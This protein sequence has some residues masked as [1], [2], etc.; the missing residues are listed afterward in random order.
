MDLEAPGGGAWAFLLR[1][2]LV[3]RVGAIDGIDWRRG[4]V[5][6]VAAVPFEVR[7]LRTREALSRL[8]LLLLI[9]VRIVGSDHGVRSLTAVAIG[10]MIGGGILVAGVPVGEARALTGE[11]RALLFRK[12]KLGGRQDEAGFANLL[13]QRRAGILDAAARKDAVSARL[14]LERAS[15]EARK[16]LLGSH[17]GQ[18]GV[19][20]NRLAGDAGGKPAADAIGEAAAQHGLKNL[21]R[22]RLDE[23]RV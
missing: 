18:V 13:N 6:E 12:R 23:R 16:E 2:V 17:V 10:F 14:G 4:D 9:D 5:I 19:G 21:D 1:A 11:V 15:R 22:R 7:V 8:V 3:S 20:A